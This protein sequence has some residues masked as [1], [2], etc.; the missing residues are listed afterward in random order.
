MIY[1]DNAATT[2]PYFQLMKV[3]NKLENDYFANA[4]SFHRLGQ[5]SNEYL[6]KARQNITKALHIEETHLPLFVSSATEAN[7]LALKGYALQY[8][9]RG[10][11]II[12]SNIEHPSILE[13]AKQLETHF[14]F[15]ITILEVNKQGVINLEDLKKALS[16][17][18]ILVSIMAVNN[19]IGSINPIKEIA[20]L[21]HN[22]SRAVLHV[23]VTQAIGKINLPYE[24][25]DMFS[26]SGHKINSFK[27]SGALV[28]R[29]NITLFPLLSGGNQEYGFRS[30][31]ISVA[32]AYTLSLALEI[33]LKN[34]NEK[35]ENIKQLFLLLYE[36]LEN[37]DDI[38]INSPKDS[39]PFIFNFSLIE[40]K[41][42]IVVEALS[43]KKIYVSSFS[44]CQTNVKGYSYVVKA[45][46]RSEKESQNTIRVSFDYHSTKEEVLTFLK[47]FATIIE[48]IKG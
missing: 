23:D 38:L 1:L 20:T 2:K 40:K 44:A 37:R 41:A 30:S 5:E 48:E 13:T 46:G 21:V 9:N 26:F 7:N 16:K 19:E 25:I 34:M 31:T 47:H 28:I 45:L 42:S 11:H 4:Q 3:F 24:Q 43:N 8:Q 33:S 22:N 18:T 35:Y 27:N 12:I 36:T 6:K 32:L 14:G 39:S 10:K 29:K 15:E 17:K